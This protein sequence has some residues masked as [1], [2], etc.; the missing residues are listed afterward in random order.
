[1]LVMVARNM[2]NRLRFIAM[3]E[4]A[5]DVRYGIRMMWSSP[6]FT[7]VALLALALGI[8]TNTAI[9]SVVNAIL[10]RP[11][12]YR[13]A[14]RLV[15]VWETNESL[16]VKRTGPS[17][18]NYLDWRDESGSFEELA[19]VEPG[20][21]TLTG[22]GEPEQVP[23]MRVTWNFLP[24]LETGMAL[25]R[26]FRREE[27]HDSGDN[28]AVLSYGFWQRRFGGDPKIL[29]QKAT[30]DGLIYTVIGVA[31]GRAWFP[32]PADVFV[33][34]SDKDLQ[35]MDRSRNDFG[36]IGRLKPGVSVEQAKSEVDAIQKRINERYPGLLGKAVTV[37]PLADVVVEG[38]RTPLLILVG[39]VG[40]VLLIASTNV[41]NLLMAR[42]ASRQKEVAVRTALGAGKKRLLRQFLTESVVLSVTGGGLGLLLSLWGVALLTRILPSAVPIPNTSA[43]ALVAQIQVDGV[44][45]GFTLVVS[46]VTGLIFGVVPSFY[47]ATMSLSETLKQS[48]RS[49][50]PGRGHR[51]FR[52]ALVAAEVAIAVVLLTGAGLMMY[53][54]YRLQRAELGFQAQNVLTMQ[55]ELPTDTKYRKGTERSAFLRAVL[56]EIRTVPGVRSAGLTETLPLDPRVAT[57]RFRIESEAPLANDQQHVAD[58]SGVSAGYFRTLGVGLIRGRAFTDADSADAPRVA[59]V[60]DSLVRRH[61]AEGQPVGRRLVIG[62]TPWEI[63]GVVRDVKHAGLDKSPKATIYVPYEQA[64]GNLM[65]LVVRTEGEPRRL[66][67]AL[68]EAVWRVDKDQP[69][70]RIRSMDEVVA[71]AS[72]PARL[73]LIVLSVFAVLALVMAAIGVYGVMSFSVSQRR[74][75]IGIRLALGGR[76]LEIFGVVMRHGLLLAT[77][78]VASGTLVALVLTRAL[79]T[80]L[81]EVSATDP[82]ILASV[83]VVLLMTAMV[84]SYLPARRA[85]RVEPIVTLRCE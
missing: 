66:T 76:P 63:I 54:F 28:V 40:F 65:T 84:A 16:G 23:G 30:V 46:V 73:T 27:G 78:G 42:A 83:G 24:M 82:V 13:H 56:G 49:S 18:P 35:R 72:V 77:L 1:M 9:F 31:S 29:G 60:S 85:T 26:S 41:A 12:P 55:M 5:R 43:E 38:I 45:L 2:L 3:H 8:G 17:G 74:Q 75:E 47:A 53:S 25:G 71:Q 68:K 36:V 22:L 62:K 58:Y 51:R 10:L 15:V 44:V 50:S 19:L 80:V 32:V 57:R 21:G 20:S 34:F 69:L 4:I 70:F 67:K 14:D 37:V 81:Y 79:A 64:P 11:L 48:G 33:P 59:I 6:G 52:D 7:A 39:A 61:F